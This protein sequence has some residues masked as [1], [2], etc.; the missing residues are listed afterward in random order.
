[1]DE[2]SSESPIPVTEGAAEAPIL[3][4]EAWGQIAAQTL[5]TD[6]NSLRLIIGLPTDG[7]CLNDKLMSG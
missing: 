6:V 7:F 2:K 4:T 5:P 3:N 1:M